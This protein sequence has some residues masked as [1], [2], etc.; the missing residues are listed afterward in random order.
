VQWESPEL[1]KCATPPGYGTH[2]ELKL[3]I[4]GIEPATPAVYF[5]YAAPI[6]SSLSPRF[7]P[8]VGNKTMIVTGSNF[9]TRHAMAVVTVNTIPCISQEWVSHSRIDCVTPPGVGKGHVV[10]VKV[11]QRT[12]TNDEWMLDYLAPVVANLSPDH[13]PTPGSYAILISGSDFSTGAYEPSLQY[14]AM[15]WQYDV[16]DVG[17]PVPFGPTDQEEVIEKKKNGK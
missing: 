6:V 10:R 17:A 13:G 15:E 8:S 14:E 1:I 12:S 11:D 3:V 16:L 9:G 2:H 4:D 5:D 7:S